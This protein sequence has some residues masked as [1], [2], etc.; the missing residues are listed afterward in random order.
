MMAAC[1][2]IENNLGQL[3]TPLRAC[4]NKAQDEYLSG[5]P[6]MF[7]QVVMAYDEDGKLGHTGVLRRR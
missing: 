2:G 3:I 5:L 7:F 6:D 4:Y 1:C